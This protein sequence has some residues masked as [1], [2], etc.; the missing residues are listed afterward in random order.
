MRWEWRRDGEV[1]SVRTNC[2]RTI[3]AVA[4][5]KAFLFA[6]RCY[7]WGRLLPQNVRFAF[8]CAPCLEN[9]C[10]SGVIAP[11]VL[12]LGSKWGRI[13]IFTY[14][15]LYPQESGYSVYYEKSA[16]QPVLHADEKR[17]CVCSFRESNT[18]SAITRLLSSLDWTV[19]ALW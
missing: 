16:P 4:V 12:N 14:R 9:I 5:S 19:T 6:A 13:F 3:L 18:D 15:P 17:Q 1:T 7:T 11:S 10:G 8:R 2:L